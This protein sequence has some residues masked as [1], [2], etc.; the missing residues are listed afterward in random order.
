MVIVVTFLVGRAVVTTSGARDNSSGP[1]VLP[2]GPARERGLLRA[3]A[4]EN[5]RVG[6]LRRRAASAG[7]FSLLEVLIVVAIVGILA[8]VAIGITPEIVRSTKGQAGVQELSAFLKRHRELA[9]SRRR[10]IEIAFT[11]PNRLESRQRA[12][13]DPPN[14]TPAPTP[15]ET[16]RLEG[17][18]AFMLFPAMPDTP[19]AFGNAAAISLGGANPVMFTSEGS[20]TDVNGDPINASLYLGVEGQPTSANALTIVGVTAAIRT[21]RWDGSRWVK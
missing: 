13:P 18:V 5:T 11:A 15:L 20:F 8:A 19:D 1:S 16:L 14:P 17:S 2:E 12:V 4:M 9:I 7:G 6:R 21:W 3:V 10:N